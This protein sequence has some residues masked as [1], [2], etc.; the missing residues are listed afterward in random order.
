MENMTAF[1]T[2]EDGK[3]SGKDATGI[4]VPAASFQHVQSAV[5]LHKL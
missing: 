3:E 4:K 1:S 2:K 5:F